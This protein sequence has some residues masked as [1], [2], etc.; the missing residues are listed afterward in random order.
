MKEEK[1]KG[2][3]ED[4]KKKKKESFSASNGRKK[5]LSGKFLFPNYFSKAFQFLYGNC[6]AYFCNS[7]YKER[8]ERVLIYLTIGTACFVYAILK[9]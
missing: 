6:P 4:E 5:N 2:E 8:R 1:T 7:I 3:R 9:L